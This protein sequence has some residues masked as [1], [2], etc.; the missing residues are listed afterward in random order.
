MILNHKNTCPEINNVKSNIEIDFKAIFSS[1]KICSTLGKYDSID[2]ILKS[3]RSNVF[4]EIEKVRSLN[5]DLRKSAQ[6]Q[7]W[8]LKEQYEQRINELERDLNLKYGIIFDI[9]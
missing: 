2:F 7:M 4:E 1:I 5:L 8:D 6:N 9:E 3:L